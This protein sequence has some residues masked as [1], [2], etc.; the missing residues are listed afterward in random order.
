[1]NNVFNKLTNSL[2]EEFKKFELDEA[3]QLSMSKITGCDL[4]I[5]N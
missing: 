3:I 4:Q 5:N 1:M 2:S